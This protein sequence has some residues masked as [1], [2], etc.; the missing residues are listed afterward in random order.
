M[1]QSPESKLYI[2]SMQISNFKAVRLVALEPDAEWNVVGGANASGKSSTLDAIEVALRG[3][4]HAPADMIHGDENRCEIILDLG[5]YLVKRI[6]TRKTDQLV[7]SNA[8]GMTAG[9]PQKLL[10]RLYGDRTIDPF[11]FQNMPPAAQA[12]KIMDL[13]GLDFAKLDGQRSAAYDKRTQ[14]NR[15][16]KGARH[17][18]TTRPGDPNGVTTEVVL[19]AI[20]SEM[21]KARKH[22]EDGARLSSV[23]DRRC[24]AAL[25]A[26]H[27]RERAAKDLDEAERNL[28]A[29]ETA[30]SDAKAWLAE[31]EKVSAAFVP[32]DIA[33]F[34]AKLRDAEAANA[35]ARENKAAA[36]AR[37]YIGFLADEKKEL[38][39]EIATIDVTKAKT[40]AEAE[41]PVDG[42]SFAPEGGLLL[43]DHPFEQASSA[44]KW[45]VSV[46][47]GIA[48]RPKLGV[49]LVRDGEKLDDANRAILKQMCA[50]GGVQIFV[51]DCRASA[52]EA[53]III[54]DGRVKV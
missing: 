42:L 3:T 40:V 33:E 16:L 39:A 24:G 29:A 10:D 23:T 30:E 17:D 50:D 12:K 32:I 41:F 26:E 31:A 51:E 44:E 18:K 43:N 28:R 47:M 14:V 4:R 5:D 37:N 8:E 11:E 49:L 54:A 52:E 6:K 19:T 46:A 53:T 34:D 1:K 21:E 36:Q 2:H 13:L 48:L 38:D 27:A 35:A 20:F 7:V 22:N 25:E 9:S 45:K 15:D